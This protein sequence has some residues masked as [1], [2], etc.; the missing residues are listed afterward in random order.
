M[1]ANNLIR[2]NQGKAAAELSLLANYGHQAVLS[3]KYNLTSKKVDKK[4]NKPSYLILTSDMA[5]WMYSI[6][7]LGSW[8]PV[9]EN[10]F[11]I[12]ASQRYR[13]NYEKLECART[14]SDQIINCQGVDF[15][16]ISG[17]FGQKT[18]YGLS[19]SKD[20]KQVSR[21]GF[22]NSTSPF[23]VHSEIG[24]S[25]KQS[26]LIHKDLY[27]SLFHQ[28]YHLNNADPEH[29]SL[30]YDDFPNMRVFRIE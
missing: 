27:F 13:L 3:S 25:G 16:L 6:S 22:S 8:D 14:D 9:G 20:G 19:I 28:L 5:N 4:S 12:L 26:Y 30:V 21:R 23:V 29:F 17:S 10:L 11:F 7:R 2:P 18:L 1:I 24:K 15:N